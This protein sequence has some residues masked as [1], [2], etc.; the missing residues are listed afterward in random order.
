MVDVS[1]F[2]LKIVVVYLSFNFAS[3]GLIYFACLWLGVFLDGEGERAGGRAAK[4]G[5][6]PLAGSGDNPAEK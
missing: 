3:R 5:G 4:G 2:L 1:L 6:S